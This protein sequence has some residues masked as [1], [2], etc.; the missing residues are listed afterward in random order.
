MRAIEASTRYNGKVV[1][2][3]HARRRTPSPP[4]A[5]AP[6]L[7]ILRRLR[8]FI[9]RRRRH[10]AIAGVMAGGHIGRPWP[11]QADDADF[12]G[13]AC[14][15]NT[16]GR[17]FSERCSAYGPSFATRERR[18]RHAFITPASFQMPSSCRHDDARRDVPRSP[19]LR[20]M[21]RQLAGDYF[22]SSGRPRASRRELPAPAR[23]RYY[24]NAKMR[25]IL[26]GRSGRV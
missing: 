19:R 22:A 15:G 17:D 13:G 14:R 3:A 24:G 9:P 26:L 7:S 4:A 25:K 18:I 6:P 23:R 12:S 10:R 5:H 20:K 1:A 21:H 8:R 11:S 2:H 16:T